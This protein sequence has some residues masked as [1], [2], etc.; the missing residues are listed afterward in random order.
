LF[1]KGDTH[2]AE[3]TVWDASKT[4]DPRIASAFIR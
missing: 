4:R 1:A 2:A 3:G